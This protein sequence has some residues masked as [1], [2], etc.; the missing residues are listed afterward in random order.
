MAKEKENIT[1]KPLLLSRLKLKI[2]GK[3]PY[4]PEPMDESVLDLYD[5]KKSNQSFDKDTRSEEDKLKTKIYKTSDGKIGIPVRCFYKA[6][7]RASSYQFEKSDGGMRNI[8]EGITIYGDIIPLKYKKMDVHK[9]WG[10]TSGSSKAPRRILRNQI[11]DWS[12]EIEIE[13][14]KNQLSAEQIVNILNYAG[15]YIG[16][17]GFRKECS[18]TFGSFCVDL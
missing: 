13:Y 3:T 18:G 14:N 6:M 16:V 2:K 4:L 11:H 1:I 10:R 8:R 9:C 7:V 12:C 15:F 5:K 17:G